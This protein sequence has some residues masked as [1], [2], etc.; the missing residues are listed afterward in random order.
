MDFLVLIIIIGITGMIIG[1]GITYFILISDN[2]PSGTFVID[3]TDPMKDVC[4]FEMDESLETIYSKKQIVLN[5]KT[6]GDFSP[7]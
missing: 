7:K 6:Y 3:L 2:K 4:R 1:G 5:V